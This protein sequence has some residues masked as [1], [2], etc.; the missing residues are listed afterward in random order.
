MA[1]A[2]NKNHNGF[3]GTQTDWA[4]YVL[5][6]QHDTNYQIMS[7]IWGSADWATVWDEATSSPKQILVNVYDMNPD[8]WHPVQITVDATDEI[9]EKH[10]QWL[11]NR[12]Y[13]RLLG[14]ATVESK[15]IQ[16][17]TI[18]KV[19]KGKSGKGTVGKVVVVMSALYGMGYRA[20]RENKLGIATSDIQ[21]DKA[22]PS[23]KVVKAY[24]DMVW[25]WA[26]NCERVDVPAIDKNALLQLAQERVV[27][28][29]AA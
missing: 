11:I 4:G 9:R 29:I 25:V 17:G 1:I 24:K 20:S 16:K 6:K 22:L 14:N 5:E 7:D 13:E 10:K 15:H 2:W 19:V 28:S 26:R 27:R 23:G 21:Y 18:A 8:G 3:A 12:E